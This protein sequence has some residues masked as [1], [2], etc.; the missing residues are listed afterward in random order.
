MTNPDPV[1]PKK[2]LKDCPFCGSN[3]NCG[4]DI[5]SEGKHQWY[6]SCDK[7]NIYMPSDN[8][9]LSREFAIEAWNTRYDHPAKRGEKII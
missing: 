5:N 2:E 8:Y 3:E 7:C 6:V 1:F 4:V 9:Y